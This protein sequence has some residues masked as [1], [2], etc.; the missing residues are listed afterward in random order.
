MPPTV[1]EM[2]AKREEVLARARVLRSVPGSGYHDNDGTGP[3]RAPSEED[4]RSAKID[5]HCIA[6]KLVFETILIGAC[7][8]KAMHAIQSFALNHADELRESRLGQEWRTLIE[9][10]VEY[11]AVDLKN[12]CYVIRNAQWNAVLEILHLE[13]VGVTCTAV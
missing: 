5:D 8:E 9:T 3:I 11:A 4:R 7:A 1:K 12:D 2:T 6:F 13:G 10:A